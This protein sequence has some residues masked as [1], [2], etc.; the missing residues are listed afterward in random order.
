MRATGF[1]SIVGAGCGR[2]DLITVRGLRR[3]E[4]CDAVIYD[5]LI[6]PALLNSLPADA[7]K[8]YMGKRS[9]HHSAPQEEINSVLITKAAEGK[10]VVRLK[11]GDPFVFGR[12][13]EEA[14]ALRKAG[15]RYEEIPGIS[16]S[17]AIPAAAGI[18][19][20]H[21]GLSRSF[22]VITAHTADTAA[23]LPDYMDALAQ[24]P[25]TLVFLMGLSKLEL[26]AS[27]LISAGMPPHMPA[28]VISG[29]NSSYPA[30]V[31][32]SLADIAQKTREAG[33]KPPAVIVIGK[34]AALDLSPTLT[35]PLSGVKVALTGTDAISGKLE[36]ML[37]QLGAE[38]YH[39]QRSRIIE[40]ESDFDFSVLSGKHST[41]IFTSSNGVRIFFKRLYASADIRLLAS[42]RFAVIGAAT[43]NELKKY[44][45]TADLCPEEYTSEAL[46][47]LLLE[48]TAVDDQLYLFRS[49]LGSQ[50][51]YENLSAERC[52]HDVHL[53][54]LCSDS[55]V[56]E[57]ARALLPGTDY[58]CFSSASGVRLFLSEHGCI[59]EKAACVCI[60]G[61]TADELYK[62][63]AKAF[64]L[65]DDISADGIVSAILSHHCGVSRQ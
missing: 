8:I 15:V 62:H 33:V 39:A 48:Q 64:L 50:E 44:G 54:T 36:A 2:A 63:G 38:V 16:S 34:T 30:V 5:D 57:S 45:I 58:I 12:G 61:V 41:V 4:S 31:R 23:G 52:V 20:T 42:C 13:G 46:G 59:P 29:G 3:L 32:A 18:P 9:G 19:V 37:G 24:L 60:G 21:R 14:E 40:L 65:A 35:Q 27:R 26:I 1:V 7:E 10:R 22:H 49:A 55:S 17:I 56:S 51:L 53:Y 11:G 25:G 28:A 47:A 43:K 6:D